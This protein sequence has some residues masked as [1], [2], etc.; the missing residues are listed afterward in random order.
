MID[1]KEEREYFLARPDLGSETDDETL[2]HQRT[3][4][5]EDRSK[6]TTQASAGEYRWFRPPMSSAFSNTGVIS[7]I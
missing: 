4:P 1:L 2:L 6:Y 3:I 5:E 7:Q